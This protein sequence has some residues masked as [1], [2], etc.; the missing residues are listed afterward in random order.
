MTQKMD[1]Y[2]W[3][4]LGCGVISETFCRGLKGISRAKLKAVAARSLE[5]AQEFADRTDAEMAYGSYEELL[6]D[7]EIEIVYIG[8]IHTFHKELAIK[9]LNAGKAVICEKPM[10]IR[11]SDTAAVI[12]ASKDNN[13]FLMEAMWTR[14]LPA[15]IDIK[16]KINDGLIGDI[17]CIH[18]DF[19]FLGSDDPKGRHLD[20]N[21]GGGALLDVGVYPIALSFM[22]LGDPNRIDSYAHIGPTG[23]DEYNSLLFS[24][25]GAF[26]NLTS[27]VLLKGTERAL[28]IGSKGNIE[29]PVFWG[30]SGY[31]LTL[32]DQESQYIDHPHKINGYEYEAE[33]VMNCLDQGLTESEIIPHAES[34][35]IASL[36]DECFDS[37]GIKYQC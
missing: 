3:G 36:I 25:D 11:A 7:P 1:T 28:I 5:R 18:A 33:E 19:S 16:Q 9:A 37:W 6:A 22:I 23:V 12:Q 15:M 20:L 10:A 8:V 14:F 32:N 31:K 13:C 35:A 29:I 4:I 30:A 17:Q 21:K 2:N 27:G 24:Y 34:L 26:A